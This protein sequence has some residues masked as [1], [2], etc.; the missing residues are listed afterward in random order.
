ML[1]AEADI[2]M[3]PYLL[4][5]STYGVKNIEKPVTISFYESSNLTKIDLRKHPV[6]AIYGANGTGKTALMSS[7]L[8]AKSLLTRD[9]YLKTK[10]VSY[11]DSLINKKLTSFFFSMDFAIYDEEKSDKVS[12]LYSYAITVKKQPNGL[13]AIEK[14][15]L[16]EI[17]SS[18]LNGA[19][20]PLYETNKGVLSIL[21]SEDKRIEDAVKGKTLNLLSDSTLSSLLMTSLSSFFDDEA[22]KQS[23]VWVPDWL[24]VSLEVFCLFVYISVSLENGDKHSFSGM[25][26]ADKDF[27][28]KISGDIFKS[29]VLEKRALSDDDYEDAIPK[30][31]IDAYMQKTDQLA[32]FIQVFKPQLRRIEVVKRESEHYYHCT[33]KMVYENYA[34]D[35]EFE[36]T[37]IKKLIALFP[38]LLDASK[39][40]I[41]FIDEIDSGLSGVYLERLIEYFVAYGE[42]QLVFTVH[43][44]DP[45]HVLANTG[46]SIYFLGE[47]NTIAPWIKNSH[48]RP[49]KLYPEGMIEGSPFNLN[50]F[51]FLSVFGDGK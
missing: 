16:K 34:V 17:N 50:S 22:A 12:N 21:K 4:R 18:S 29:L 11:F 23:G 33:K 36:S 13:Y 40:H 48:Y 14:E 10:D 6:T 24:E 9:S 49:Y 35:P 27:L 43:S 7:L 28:S 1:R 26:G 47:G 44:M 19:S 51:D 46:K 30:D 42:G 2:I 31:Q 38:F 5:I 39:G 20:T 41:V 8:F 3:K 37:G 45:M 25:S 32:K 15:S